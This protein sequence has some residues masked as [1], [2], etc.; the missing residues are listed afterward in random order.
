MYGR[1]IDHNMGLNNK[2]VKVDE[3]IGIVEWAP[4][5]E[6]VSYLGNDYKK[7]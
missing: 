2:K 3:D 5:D 6:L 1:G 4:I 7:F